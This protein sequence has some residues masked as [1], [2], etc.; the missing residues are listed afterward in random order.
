MKSAGHEIGSHT[1]THPYLTTL[2]GQN[3]INEVNGSK[4]D[5]SNTMGITGIN[6]FVYPYGD[7]DQNVKQAVI[8]AGYYG[9]RSV[10]RGL[11]YRD[12][13][14]FALKVQQVDRTTNLAQFQSWLDD[15]RNNNAWLILMFHQVDNNPN[16]TLGVSPALFQQMVDALVAQQVTVVTME[17]G[18]GLMNP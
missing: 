11:N 6:T 12:T 10:D 5:L 8:N 13:D 1:Q 17:Q 2:S 3:L 14:K 7:Y 4:T 9:G 18:L 16:A 15:A